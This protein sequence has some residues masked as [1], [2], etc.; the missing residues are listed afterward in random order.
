MSRLSLSENWLPVA[1][2]M[3]WIQYWI[4]RA[5]EDLFPGWSKFSGI[6]AY[7]ATSELYNSQTDKIIVNQSCAVKLS[8][9][10]RDKILYFVPAADFS[11]PCFLDI[12]R[13]GINKGHFYLFWYSSSSTC[14]TIMI[15]CFS[16]CPAGGV[17][18]SITLH[19]YMQYHTSP[20]HLANIIHAVRIY[21]DI[22][23]MISNCP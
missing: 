16:N 1:G 5:I 19:P 12:M 22:F 4:M 9:N 2:V 3:L 13:L 21:R 14:C 15:Y 8:F 11:S 7:L 23:P 20:W 10:L 18:R 6:E 17:L